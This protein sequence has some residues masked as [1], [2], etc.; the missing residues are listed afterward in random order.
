MEVGGKL[1]APAAVPPRN[2]AGTYQT[3]GWVCP[4]S[5]LDV[6]KEEKNLF[7]LPDSNT[8]RL[9]TTFSVSSTFQRSR[10][11]CQLLRMR[12]KYGPLF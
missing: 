7:S 4:T 2:N 12:L 9:V 8:G 6:L 10:Q 1:P 5:G 11:F 3:G